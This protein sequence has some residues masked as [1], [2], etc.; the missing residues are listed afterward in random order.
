MTEPLVS[1]IIPSKNRQTL[2]QRAIKSVSNQD[3]PNIEI[4]VI[5]DGSTPKL[6]LAELEKHSREKIINLVRND[7]SLG[8][9][10]SRNIGINISKGEYIAFLDDDDI[11]YQNKISAL[12]ATLSK[13]H[14]H[15]VAFGRTVLNDG[16]TKRHPIKYPHEF[17]R[18]TN[19]QLMNYIHTGSSL[20][21]KTALENTRFLETLTR[22]QDLQFYIELTVK[23]KIKFLD[24]DVC[25]WTVD[26]RD[27]QITSDNSNE[28]IKKS[29]IALKAVTE[30]LK[31]NLRLSRSEIAQYEIRT[32]ILGIKAKDPKSTLRLLFCIANPKNLIF[33]ISDALARKRTFT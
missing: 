31:K 17:D 9:A 18:K 26:G 24:Q 30:H 22:Y 16:K 3:Y 23:N 10:R 14:E 6:E 27:D 2:I 12:V 19:I 8:G 20:I 32:H 25:E 29:F 15:G 33:F 1:V 11:Y 21:R 7:I 5:D 4:I 28:K 13:H